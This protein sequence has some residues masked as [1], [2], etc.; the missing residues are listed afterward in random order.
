MMSLILSKS[1]SPDSRM[2]F[3]A[4]EL[5]KPESP[6]LV[7]LPDFTDSSE[8]LRW[9]REVILGGKKASRKEGA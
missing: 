6:L 2:V 8:P 5:E 4:V 3:N 7:S 9:R 1:S